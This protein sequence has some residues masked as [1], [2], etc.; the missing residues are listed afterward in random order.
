MN[1][2][3]STKNLDLAQSTKDIIEDAVA[4]KI[5]PFVTDVDVVVAKEG[6]RMSVKL[7]TTAY[8]SL[9]NATG[10]D[11]KLVRALS[12]AVDIMKRKIR[13][14]KTQ[15]KITQ[16][17]AADIGSASDE[18]FSVTYIKDTKHIVVDTMT[19]EQAAYNAD[20]SD[21]NVYHYRD[22]AGC[23]SALIRVGDSFSKITIE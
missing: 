17:G 8:D 3:I 5:G 16:Q 15:A 7:R 13:R 10:D 9:I 19:D 20:M 21:R 12:D 1:V 11:I 18:D 2:N 6:R 22:E 23:L 4:K 14:A